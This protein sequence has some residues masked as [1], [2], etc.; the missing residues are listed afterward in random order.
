MLLRFDEYV[1]INTSPKIAL[2]GLN[3]VGFRLNEIKGSELIVSLES[4]EPETGKELIV[5]INE[6]SDYQGNISDMIQLPV[7]Q[8]LKAG[9]LVFNEIMFDPIDDDFDQL[10]NQ[11]DYLELTNRRPYA[12]SLEGVHL[13][14]QP[15]ENGNVRTMTPISSKSKWIPA[16]GFAVIYPETEPMDIDSSRTGIF[17]GMNDFITPH[18]LQ[19]ERSTLS[20]PLSGREIYLSDSLGTTIDMV[21]YSEVWH[22]PNLIDTKGIAL[23]RI[24][25]DGDS[26]DASNW[27]S[28]SVPLGGTPGAVNSL[29]QTPDMSAESNTL[30][31]N[32]NPFSPDADGHEDRLFISYSFDDPNYMLRARI[33]DRYGRYITTLAD[34]HHAGFEGSLIWDGRHKNGTTGRIGIY[35][36]HIEAYNSSTG[37][38]KQFKEVAVLARKF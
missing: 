14:D 28:S 27:G 16:H 17:F 4:Y 23:E 18:S 2:N 5:E 22:N 25:P 8:P 12:V 34:S 24:N 33:F 38:K 3:T 1:D 37:D 26:S 11:S 31:L 36:V 30:T 21:H 10:P 13:H 32:P 29:Y 35:I 15:D 19:I 6:V 7:A 20:L 9:D